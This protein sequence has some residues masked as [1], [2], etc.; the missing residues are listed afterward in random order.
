MG[1]TRSDLSCRRLRR[2]LPLAMVCLAAAGAVGC[3]AG[4]SNVVVKSERDGQIYR[5]Q[6]SRAY[7]ARNAEGELDVVLSSPLKRPAADGRAAETLQQVMHVRVLWRPMKGTKTDHPTA[8][9]AIL[10]WYVFGGDGRNGP[11]L[12]TYNGAAFAAVQESGG[13]TKL[14]LQNATLAPAA[15]Q[16]RLVDPIGPSDLS[17]VIVAKRSP[18]QVGAVL[19]KVESSVSAAAASARAGRVRDASTRVPTE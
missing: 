4:G 5:P 10:H 16:G 8:T 2:L 9:N 15:R 17:G 11:Q 1:L 6:F 19:A 3:S 12:L 14:T 18:R 13:V 7:A